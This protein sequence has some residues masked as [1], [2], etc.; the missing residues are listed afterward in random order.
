MG[1]Q[2]FSIKGEIVN[3]LGF[4][5]HIASLFCNDSIL[6]L[7]CESSPRQY[8]NKWACLYSNKTLFNQH[9]ALFGLPI[10]AL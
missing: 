6:P 5:G 9:L 1:W 3:I 10:P 7:K 8:I 4:A 2:T